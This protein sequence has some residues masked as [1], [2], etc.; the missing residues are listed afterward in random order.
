MALITL[1][2]GIS[3]I[4]GKIGGTVYQHSQA[5][6]I[7]KNRGSRTNK[8]SYQ[9][10]KA[11]ITVAYLN[12]VWS[13]MSA[14]DR[15]QWINF[16]L[17]K[18]TPQKNNPSRFLN[19][20]QI[21]ILSNYAQFLQFLTISTTPIFSTTPALSTFITLE[22]IAGALL[23]NSTFAIDETTDYLILKVSNRMKPTR[24][25]AVGGVK[26][27]NT[28]FANTT[29]CDITSDYTDLYGAIPSTGEFVEIQYQLFSNVATN[30]TG[31]SQLASFVA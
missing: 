11:K 23:V 6:T 9:S 27:I 4:R 1:G 8:S 7:S 5:G 30:W 14:T 25:R 15:N 31:R 21:F 22:N 13:N 12:Q 29:S 17:Y 20:Q 16:A 18:P 19:G 28:V 24:Q 3:N 2:N 26:Y 10:D